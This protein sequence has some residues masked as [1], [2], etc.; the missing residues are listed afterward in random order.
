MK[1]NLKV[2][3]VEHGHDDHGTQSRGGDV[4]EEVRER[5]AGDEHNKGRDGQPDRSLHSTGTVDG[6]PGGSARYG[7]LEK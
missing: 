2:D 5:R 4:E 3:H 1:Q 6:G 7:A